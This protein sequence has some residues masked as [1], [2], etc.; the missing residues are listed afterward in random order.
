MKSTNFGDLPDNDSDE[1]LSGCR[2]KCNVNKFIDRVAAIVRPC[3][4]VVNF[5]EMFTCESPTQ[6]YVFLI[7]SFAHGSDIERLKYV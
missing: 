6:M 7:F 1:L 5:S 4:I 3:G 2:K